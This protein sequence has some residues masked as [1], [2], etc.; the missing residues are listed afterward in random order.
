MSESTNI[1]IPDSLAEYVVRSGPR[2]GY[3]GGLQVVL[4]FPNNYGVSIVS[5]V[6][7]YGVETALLVWENDQDDDEYELDQAHPLVAPSY[8]VVGWHTPASLEEF[9]T[10]VAA[11]P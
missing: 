5:G 7:T 9:I 8:G 1:A 11:L 10:A 3:S 6:G 4:R 2:F